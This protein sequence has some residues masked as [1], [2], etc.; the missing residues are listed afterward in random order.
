MNDDNDEQKLPF[1]RWSSVHKN[2]DLKDSD[3]IVRHNGNRHILLQAKKFNAKRIMTPEEDAEFAKQMRLLARH[4]SKTAR[5]VKLFP[6]V[7]VT[8][9]LTTRKKAAR[10][11]KP[12]GYAM[13]G[14]LRF[15]LPKKVFERVVEQMILDAREEHAEALAE[16]RPKHARWIAMRLYLMVG[17]A[18]VT[19]AATFPLEKFSK[20]MQKD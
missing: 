1:L 15:L 12:P 14:A 10:I 6:G 3:F 8:E 9:T 7:N 19:K 17:L 18:L 11:Y 2:L 5:Q 13:T 4:T 16:G 20:F